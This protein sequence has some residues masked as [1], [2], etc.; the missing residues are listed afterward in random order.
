MERVEGG[1]P[2]VGEGEGEAGGGQRGGKGGAAATNW[3]KGRGRLG[4][5][6][7]VLPSIGSR[8][9]ARTRSPI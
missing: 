2:N 7:G 8:S 9:K 3:E 4:L 1:C 6:R 5:G